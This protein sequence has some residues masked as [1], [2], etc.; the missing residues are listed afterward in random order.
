MY[1]FVQAVARLFVRIVFRAKVFGLEHVPGE[2]PLI[3]CS[4]HQSNWDPVMVGALTPP[5]VSFMAKEELFSLAP[6]RWF[7][8]Q[9]HAFP[10][11]RGQ[12]DRG[13]IRASLGVLEQNGI[14][15]MFP[16]GT[17]KNRGDMSHLEGGVSFLALR[18]KAPILPVIITGEYRPFRRMT[19]HYFPPF[20]PVADARQEALT[21]A[22]TRGDVRGEQ[23]LSGGDAGSPRVTVD[24][25]TR[26][27]QRRFLTFRKEVP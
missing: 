22:A 18:S 13:A 4:N 15:V 25:V 11:K 21:E 5:P 27:I 8:L 20:D 16:E 9:L 1:E 3:L 24:Q 7:L 14:L 10:V 6:V 2:G 12:G 17:R 23:L 26:A 19:M